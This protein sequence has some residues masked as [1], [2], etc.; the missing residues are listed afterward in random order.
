M[1]ELSPGSFYA[2][3][4]MHLPTPLNTK[5]AREA[6]NEMNSC[7][8]KKNPLILALRVSEMMTV[9]WRYEQFINIVFFYYPFAQV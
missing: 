7:K 5:T 8:S 3:T 2:P 9:T 4:E 1:S 6:F